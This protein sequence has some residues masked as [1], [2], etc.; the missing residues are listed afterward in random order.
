V[1]FNI[2]RAGDL[3]LALMYL[4][5]HDGMRAWKGFD[6]AILDHLHAEGLI[7]DP[8]GKAM[9]VI[10]TDHG[11][12][13]AQ[14][15]FQALLAE[16]PASRRQT[17]TDAA[18]AARKTGLSELQEREARKLLAPLV[19]LPD[20]PRIKAQVRKDIRVEGTAIVLFESRPRF[21]R[22]A[23]WLEHPVAKFRYVK[24]RRVW[25]L[26][27]MLRD[28]KWHHYEPLPE[29]PALANLVQEVRRDPTGIF[30]G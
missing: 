22:P 14:H 7:E 21:D 9:S 20:D 6:W 28:L 3:A 1:G 26:Y 29:A 30:W 18:R 15:A 8:R 16:P 11:L 17:P 19:E 27:C 23:E 10:L 24:S 2:D 12:A 5:L 13:R 4:T 25:E